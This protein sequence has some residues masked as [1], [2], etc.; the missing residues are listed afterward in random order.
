MQLKLVRST[1][2]DIIPHVRLV[3]FRSPFCLSLSLGFLCFQAYAS[4]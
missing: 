4:I 1:C 2:W 3:Y